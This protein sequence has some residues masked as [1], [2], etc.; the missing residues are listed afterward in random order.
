M[1]DTDLLRFAQTARASVRD[2]VR[3][4]AEP[5]PLLLLASKGDNPRRVEA[6][7]IGAAHDR[8]EVVELAVA[9]L[10]EEGSYFAGVCAQLK[11]GLSGRILEV[12]LQVVEPFGTLSFVAALE[13]RSAGLRVGA[14]RSDEE[15]S[16]AGGV[17][18]AQQALRANRFAA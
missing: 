1:A 6:Y 5:P 3:K 7:R 17:E 14:W 8:A 13:H 18:W 2:Y 15:F 9:A 4:N 10:H 11:Q 12:G 16:V